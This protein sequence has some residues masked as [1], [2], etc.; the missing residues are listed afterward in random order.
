MVLAHSTL[1]NGLHRFAP[2]P[3]LSRSDQISCISGI[4]AKE[5]ANSAQFFKYFML[6]AIK[7]SLKIV[8]IKCLHNTEQIK[9][10]TSRK[11]KTRF[12]NTALNH[13]SVLENN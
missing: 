11:I 13:S 6:C 7:T 1:D 9:Y 5:I 4:H 12:K 3:L 2:N 8:D 10:N